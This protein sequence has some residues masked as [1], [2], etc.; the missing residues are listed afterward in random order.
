MCVTVAKV[1]QG[2]PKSSDCGGSLT[3]AILLNMNVL[4]QVIGILEPENRKVGQGVLILCAKIKVTYAISPLR[5]FRA[6]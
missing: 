2:R 3:Y 4:G 6:V 1:S 5:P